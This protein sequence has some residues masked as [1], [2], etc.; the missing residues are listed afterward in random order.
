MADRPTARCAYSLDGSTWIEFPK[1]PRFDIGLGVEEQNTN[2]ETDRGRRF[3]YPQFQRDLWNVTFRFTEDDR[4][5]FVDFH[6]TVDG[7][8]NPFYL[9]IT[10][11][12]A[13]LALMYGRK[14]VSFFPAGIGAYA[15][16]VVY[17]YKFSLVGEVTDL[18]TAGSLLWPGPFAGI[19]FGG[20]W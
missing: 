13:L 18:T 9:S 12:N 19:S 7:Q 5:D 6:E 20:L 15:I 2:L 11:D 16:P 1:G 4:Q 10:S 8:L 3:I 14:S 17:E